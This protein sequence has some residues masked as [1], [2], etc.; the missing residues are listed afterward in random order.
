MSYVCLN[1]WEVYDNTV[2]KMKINTYTENGLLMPTIFCPKSDCAI[3][4][5]VEID[6]LYIPVIK[7]LN[8]KGYMTKYC[9][10][11]HIYSSCT[12]SYIVF[13][14]SVT[15]LPSIPEG[16]CIEKDKTIKIY[17][18]YPENAAETELYYQI[19]DNARKMMKWVNELPI[20]DKPNYSYVKRF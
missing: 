4:N 2:E 6:E 7:Y 16:A 8:E 10:S 9:C 20:R 18:E 15:G 19:L 14:E 1:C 5:I 17:F 12:E 13:H 11:G 3:G